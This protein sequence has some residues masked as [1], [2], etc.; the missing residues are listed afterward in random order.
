VAEKI[1]LKPT[2]PGP[3]R[4]T[5]HWTIRGGAIDA[6]YR[7][8]LTSQ[9]AMSQ[10]VRMSCSDPGES[11][12]SRGVRPIVWDL[13][14]DGRQHRLL[15]GS[16][17]NGRR[18]TTCDGR[19][20]SNEDLCSASMR[21]RLRARRASLCL[22][23]FVGLYA[24]PSLA[25]GVL[26]P[27]LDPTDGQL[28]VSDWLLNKRGFL[29]NPMVITEPSVG[30]GGG[31]TALFFHESEADREREEG[32]PLGLPPSVTFAVGGATETDSWFTGAGHFGSF[33]DD[34][35]RYLGAAGYAS[36]NIEFNVGDRDLD[37]GLDGYFIVQQL[38]ARIGQSDFFVGGRYVYSR[39]E[40]EFDFGVTLPS[41]L[42]SKLT[43]DASG[44][45]PMVRY[46]SRDNIF[47]PNQG[48]EIE[49][50]PLFYTQTLGSDRTYQTLDGNSRFYVPAHERLFLALRVDTSLSF[51]DTPFYA[52]PAIRARRF[53]IGWRS[54]YNA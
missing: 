5:A 50:T 20:R 8:Q 49:I 7:V 46:D 35:L 10:S 18:G 37:Y 51:G 54:K 6:Y 4:R 23:F 15:H 14:M 9:I 42:P 48:I 2:I 45:G 17:D 34:R 13:S 33:L 11:A 53:H 19:N 30:Y 29:L 26:E 31:A 21:R 32:T 47:S 25:A 44:I 24:A 12:I 52:L 36:L 38:Q 43:F 39:L 41:F 1:L 22:F 28:D 16:Q 40:S 3:V 27:F